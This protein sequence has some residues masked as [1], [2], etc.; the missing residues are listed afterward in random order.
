MVTV[1]WYFDNV[2]I[3]IL[4]SN[5]IHVANI[6]Y[7]SKT[8][9]IFWRIFAAFNIPGQLLLKEVCILEVMSAYFASAEQP[10]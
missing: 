10:S 4:F 9:S 7:E 1:Y 5:Y 3:M 2:F 6:T 8:T